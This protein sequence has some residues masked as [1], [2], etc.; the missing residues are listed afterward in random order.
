MFDAHDA[1]EHQE[2]GDE[3]EVLRFRRLYEENYWPLRSY[4]GRRIASP[5][6]ADDIVSEVFTIAWRR[7]D[8]VPPDG[9]ALP[10]L[11]T[12]ARRTLANHR[13]GSC[14]RRA[15]GDRL[16]SVAGGGEPPDTSGDG[17]AAVDEVRTALDALRP[18][19]RD[20]LVLALTDDR[21]RQEIASL[22]GISQN[23][24]TIRLHRARRALRA[25]LSAQQRRG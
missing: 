12:V 2:G 18:S 20:L 10:W 24:V 13:R 9:P 25:V 11:Y 7:L 6:D 8:V 4:V 21:P 5:S 14:R 1:P 22:L 3:P 16:A 19:D 15:L 17:W 23:A